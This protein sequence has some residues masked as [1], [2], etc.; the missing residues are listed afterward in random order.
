M[1]SGVTPGSGSDPKIVPGLI[2]P[3]ENK[4]SA[5]FQ[6]I[7]PDPISKIKPSITQ[8]PVSFSPTSRSSNYRQQYGAGGGLGGT[9]LGIA[10]ALALATGP[11]GW[12][13]LISLTAGAGTGF[14]AGVLGYGIGAY[15]DYEAE[16]FANHFNQSK[17]SELTNELANEIQSNQ[18]KI[19]ELTEELQ[20]LRAQHQTKS[21]NTEVQIKELEN[22]IKALKLQKIKKDYE[23]IKLEAERKFGEVV[24]ECKTHL[25]TVQDHIENKSELD[26]EKF[27]ENLEALKS[28]LR[29]DR[30]S[31]EN[32]LKEVD[33][34]YNELSKDD[35]LDIAEAK[36]AQEAQEAAKEAVEK[37]KLSVA[38][39]TGGT[40]KDAAGGSSSKSLSESAEALKKALND[41][42]NSESVAN[43]LEDILRLAEEDAQQVLL[44]TQTKEG[45]KA[46]KAEEK[47][48]AAE[49][50]A[51]EAAKKEAATKKIQAAYKVRKVRVEAA[52]QKIQKIQ[53]KAIKAIKEKA[54][55]DI[56]DT[57]KEGIKSI[58]EKAIKE[59]AEKDI[60]DILFI[61]DIRFIKDEAIQAIQDIQANEDIKAQAIQAIQ[62]EAIKAI[63]EKAIQAIQEK[64]E[65]DIKPIPTTAEKD[66]QDIQTTAEASIKAIKDI[67]EK[68]NEAIQTTAEEAI[69]AIQAAVAIA[70][71]VLI[72]N[73]ATAE[74]QKA[75]AAK[76]EVEAAKTASASGED[77]AAKI[78]ALQ[79]IVE[80]LKPLQAEQ[81]ELYKQLADRLKTADTEY[82]AVLG[83]DGVEAKKGAEGAVKALET[84]VEALKKALGTLEESI[85]SLES[86]KAEEAARKA[87][88]E[89]LA[90]E[91]AEAA[92]KAE[93]EAA[94]KAA[95]AIAEYGDITTEAKAATG[96]IEEAKV[97][98]EALGKAV[99]ELEK[100]EA[101]ARKE[102]AEA[103]KKAEE[104]RVAAEA[105]EAARKAEE[106]RLA[107]EAAE[108][109]KKAYGEITTKANEATTEIKT[110][111]EEAIPATASGEDPASEGNIEALQERVEQLK[112]LKEYQ[113]K[114]YQTLKERLDQ[115][116]KEATKSGVLGA[117][118][119]PEAQKKATE[120]Q[121]KAITAKQ[122]ATTAVSALG[123]LEAVIRVEEERLAAEA[124]TA[125]Y[126]SITTQAKAATVKIEDTKKAIPSTASGAAPAAK[127]AALQAIV[128]QLNDLKADQKH[129]EL[130]SSLEAADTEYSAVLGA[131]GDGVPDAQTAQTAKKEATKAVEDLATALGELETDIKSQK[132]Q[133]VQDYLEYLKGLDV[134]RS[135]SNH[136][137]TIQ[138]IQKYSDNMETLAEWSKETETENQLNKN[139]EMIRLA[140]LKD[141]FE[142][143]GTTATSAGSSGT[144]PPTYIEQIQAVLEKL[145]QTGLTKSKGKFADLYQKAN[146]SNTTADTTADGSP[147]P[148]PNIET[149]IAMV[150][151][152]K[153]AGSLRYYNDPTLKG[154]KYSMTDFLKSYTTQDVQDSLGKTGIPWTDADLANESINQCFA[155]LVNASKK[156]PTQEQVVQYFISKKPTKGLYN[157]WSAG[158]GAGKTALMTMMQSMKK[159]NVHLFS[160]IPGFENEMEQ[161]TTKFLEAVE[162]ELSRIQS[163]EQ[164]SDDS[165]KQTDTI[166]FIFDERHT[167]SDS[168]QKEKQDFIQGLCNII[169]DDKKKIFKA[170]IGDSNDLVY[171]CQAFLNNMSLN[172]GVH[173]YIATSPGTTAYLANWLATLK[174][175]TELKLNKDELENIKSRLKELTFDDATDATLGQHRDAAVSQINQLIAIDLNKNLNTPQTQETIDS[176]LGEDP[177]KQ[178]Y[179]WLSDEQTSFSQNTNRTRVFVKSREY[180]IV[181]SREYEIT[182]DVVTQTFTSKDKAV[183]FLKKQTV[184]KNKIDFVYFGDNCYGHDFDEFSSSSKQPADGDN[185]AVEF[186]IASDNLMESGASMN[187]VQFIGRYRRSEKESLGQITYYG[188]QNRERIIEHLNKDLNT[189]PYAKDMLNMMVISKRAEVKMN[190]V[191]SLLSVDKNDATDKDAVDFISTLQDLA[192]ERINAEDFTKEMK[193]IFPC[194]KYKK[195]ESKFKAVVQVLEETE[196]DKSYPEKLKEKIKAL[197][198]ALKPQ[199][200]LDIGDQKDLLA[201]K[202]K[203]FLTLTNQKDF[204]SI[205]K[206]VAEYYGTNGETY[207]E[208]DLLPKILNNSED[209]NR[210]YLDGI[211]LKIEG[212]L[213]PKINVEFSTWFQNNLKENIL[214]RGQGGDIR[215]EKYKQLLAIIQEMVVDLSALEATMDKGDKSD[216]GIDQLKHL[217][218]CHKSEEMR[219]NPNK[220]VENLLKEVKAF[221][222]TAKDFAANAQTAATNAKNRAKTAPNVNK[223]EDAVQIVKIA[224]AD[225]KQAAEAAKATMEKVTE[226]AETAAKAADNKTYLGEETKL[227]AKKAAE[228]ANQ[229]AADANKAAEAANK[230]AEAAN[231]VVI[232]IEEKLSKLKEALQAVQ[233]A[234]EKLKNSDIGTP[235]QLEENSKTKVDKAASQ[236]AETQEY[237]EKVKQER[238]RVDDLLIEANRAAQ[239]FENNEEIIECIRQIKD[240]NNE[241]SRK[242]SFAQTK[243]ENAEVILKAAKQSAKN[244]AATA[245]AAADSKAR[246][247]AKAAEAA[248]KADPKAKAKA[249]PK[250]KAATKSAA[251]KP[252]ADPKTNPKS[253]QQPQPP[254]S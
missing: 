190:I 73:E 63:K 66:I 44:D 221:A 236:L 111:L 12:V 174:E 98:V 83:A 249:D 58:K 212:T 86:K 81:P 32:R 24:Y 5:P 85:Q 124:A 56:P 219:L 19:S 43:I 140:F 187:V 246:K 25:K 33:E 2:N 137:T 57:F 188:K 133:A 100:A 194:G 148:F 77:T 108:A 123:E 232:N 114:S 237:M 84:A 117:E 180:V 76:R 38:D 52:I 216:Y 217:K 49:K 105:A 113:T 30:K 254:A 27:R 104:R 127:I 14:G 118:G 252:K 214:E 16:K 206:L 94:K 235:P 122:N 41:P 13:F 51:A 47:R 78:A 196:L 233:N 144:N 75:E 90:A 179:F 157:R 234:K 102:S 6:G 197:I 243:V 20:E 46:Q 156:I 70:E 88:E 45:K 31:L 172:I 238:Q 95:A 227:I 149:V 1:S 161:K 74:I 195:H 147:P 250:A 8:S 158:T 55:K 245:A 253:K 67:K 218:E 23:L 72:T 18:D 36:E 50:A 223:L 199:E 112:E 135:D 231:Q 87:E 251:T 48:V 182:T 210:N 241:L 3:R 239:G 224:A 39:G 203:A 189:D 222:A 168:E 120:A 62:E 130:Q 230:A 166:A 204:N 248:A 26:L 121:T 155:E 107:A 68:S 93:A 139:E 185:L 17:A 201:A 170:S 37:L 79:S 154:R 101:A 59:K 209:T 244:A 247:E 160:P 143:K 176:V 208:N 229:V 10:V 191:N 213:S 103:A 207:K 167:F 171:I 136:S 119:V 99:G 61:K 106:E 200:S 153:H 181:K 205:K 178:R 202:Q 126:E 64:A 146:S 40:P 82:S 89:R 28:K 9:A 7:V 91:A 80:Q 141:K 11:V 129:E 29:N 183:E 165:A 131:E 69:K 92:R 34:E 53:E 109:A 184:A 134:Q 97:A 4:A 15:F 65:K 177:E 21:D 22:K 60:Q 169:P 150:T 71:Y 240:R 198:D 228:T 132:Q 193:T 151:L 54:I 211:R 152:K 164:A 162:T 163:P 138:T 220:D 215:R 125:A 116:D 128:E 96:K 186:H 110:K 42:K 242:I 225:A 145:S 159:P 175:L 226:A 115:V 173:Q 142:R 35:S 192:L